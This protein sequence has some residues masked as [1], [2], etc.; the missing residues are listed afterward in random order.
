M[1]DSYHLWTV[2]S[3]VIDHVVKDHD[4]FVHF[5]RIPQGSK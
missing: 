5:R 3:G 4:L 1:A 2:D